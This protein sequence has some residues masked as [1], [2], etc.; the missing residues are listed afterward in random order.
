MKSVVSSARSHGGHVLDI[1]RMDNRGVLV[2]MLGDP[3]R[4]RFFF[5][6]FNTNNGTNGIICSSLT[7]SGP[8]PFSAKSSSVLS[9]SIHAGALAR[10]D[11]SLPISA[12][13]TIGSG[14]PAP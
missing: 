13:L 8:C 3:A 10:T 6:A 1:V 9:G 12:R 5:N 14:Q 4:L 7:K 11:A 2:V